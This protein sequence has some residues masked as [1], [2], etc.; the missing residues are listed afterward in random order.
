MPPPGRM[1]PLPKN[2]RRIPTPAAI[3][4]EWLAEINDL[5][6]LK[7][8]LRV[9]A[10]LGGEPAWRDVPP[11]LPL[12]DLLD[13]AVLSRAAQVGDDVAIR[14]ALGACLSRGTLVAARVGGEIRIWL[15][16]EPCRS[17]LEKAQLPTLGPDDVPGADSAERLPIGDTAAMPTPP[18][19]ANIFEMYEQHIGTFGHGMAEQLRA[20]EEE[21]PAQWIEDAFAAAVERNVR[22]WIYVNAILKRWL[23]EGRQAEAETLAGRRREHDYDHGKPRHDSA[24]DSRTGYLES[25][26]RRH[27]R[28]PWE[29]DDSHDGTRG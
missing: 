11:S 28:L 7:L 5:T 13:D 3:L 16:D 27:G 24:P 17:Y 25:Y 1:Q 18:P 15:N 2:A 12:D 23:Q 29:S 22:S 19:R 26:R 14:Q 21:Y 4:G 6:E 20:A 9:A 8:V 10:L